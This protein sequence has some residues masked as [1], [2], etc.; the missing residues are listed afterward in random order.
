MKTL[1]KKIFGSA[2]MALL[3]CTILTTGCYDD[4]A[5]WRELN[6]HE[7]RI[8]KL[9]LLTE[10]YNT[11]L[12]SLQDILNAMKDKDYVTNVVPVERNGK[13]VGDRKSVV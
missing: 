8:V 5:L 9:E 7:A 4:S 12:S 11:N 10:E 13:E 3:F 2:L 6:E 1:G